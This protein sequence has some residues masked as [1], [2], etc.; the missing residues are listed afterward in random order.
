MITSYEQLKGI[1][2]ER[3]Q[4]ILVLEVD[5]SGAYS[6]EYE[7]AKQEVQQA[8]VISSLVGGDF[9]APPKS[10]LDSLKPVGDPIWLKFRRLPLQ[11]WKSLTKRGNINALD[12]YESILPDTFIGLYGDP[13]G[14]PLTTDYH[15]VGTGD[16]SLLTGSML[17]QVMQAMLQWQ[18]S[19]GE[20]SVNPQK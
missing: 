20:I 17:M 15:H 2:E 10:Q 8:Q 9:L 11:A 6:P 18:N 19:G 13:A 3:R 16:E 1:I 7:K 14:E 4:D 5:I 12:Q